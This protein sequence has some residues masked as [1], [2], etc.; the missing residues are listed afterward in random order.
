[1]NA[2][3]RTE[4]L[5]ESFAKVHFANGLAPSK[6]RSGSMGVE[7]INAL[8]RE[9]SYSR[10]KA[11]LL[12]LYIRCTQIFLIANLKKILYWN[13]ELSQVMYCYVSL[14]CITLSAQFH[15]ISLYYVSVYYVMFGYFDHDHALCHVMYCY[16]LLYC[17]T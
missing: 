6:L 9:C 10:H 1:M 5:D 8:I 17:I 2:H 3:I 16:V 15:Y 12:T 13:D 7:N 14:Y 11:G 4:G